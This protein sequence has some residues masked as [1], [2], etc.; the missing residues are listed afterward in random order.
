MDPFASFKIIP[1]LMEI[2]TTGF[3]LLSVYNSIYF[4]AFQQASMMNCGEE[5]ELEAVGNNNNTF[6]DRW[7]VHSDKQ[8]DKELKSDSFTS[9]LPRYMDSLVELYSTLRQI[10]YPVYFSRWLINSYVKNLLAVASVQKKDFDLLTP[11]D[12][13]FAKGKARLLHYYNSNSGKNITTKHHQVSPMSLS[14]PQSPVL[15]LYAPINRFY[16]MDISLDRS[17]VRALLS[18]GLDVYLLDW[19]YPDWNDS[20]LSLSD[21]V[22]YVKDAVQIIKDKTG[23]DKISILAY[24][25]GGIIGT[26]Y[27]ALNN[28][29]LKSLVLMGVPID[30]SKDNTILTSWAKAIDVDKMID[31]FDH[32]DGLPIDFAFIMRN[33][34]RYAF[35]R[36]IKLFERLHDKQFVN[37]FIALQKW[38]SDTPPIPG[39]LYRQIINDCYKNNLLITNRMRIDGRVVDLRKITVPLLTIV[40]KHDDL[41][42]PES[43][44]SVNHFVSSREKIT[45][46]YSGDHIGLCVSS[47]AHKKLWPEVSEWIISK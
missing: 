38:L 28:E 5:L 39:N 34:P 37:T 17:V 41:V 44:L 33:P 12:V 9:L 16:I 47:I 4:K 43:T 8:L 26:I 24:C 23:S 1:S 3:E 42:S 2:Y 13:M 30:F 31:E 10:G 32:I 25:W 29:S 22:N 40:A 7:R 18:R 20:C 11:F 45:R 15:L 19:G 14:P 6:Y 27:A 35:D 36:Y 46:V 21:Y